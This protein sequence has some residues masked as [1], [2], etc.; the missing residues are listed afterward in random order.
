[1]KPRISRDETD[2]GL[3][4]TTKSPPEVPP[5]DGSTEAPGS[6]ARHRKAVDIDGE[7]V[8]K[9]KDVRDFRLHAERGCTFW[10][11]NVEVELRDRQQRIAYRINR[12]PCMDF[13]VPARGQTMNVMLYS[14]NGFSA[15]ANTNEL[16][17]PDL[18]WRDVLN[19]H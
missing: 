14:C 8:Q 11:F 13:W 9:Y 3:F 18:L 12:G 4:E 15:S 5:A 6:F 19:T 1:M 10:R 17:G 2:N 7:K 16:S